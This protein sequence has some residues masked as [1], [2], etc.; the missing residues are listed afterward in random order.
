MFNNTFQNHRIQRLLKQKLAGSEYSYRMRSI[1]NCCVM[2]DKTNG[3]HVLSNGT[4][5]KI[6]GVKHCNHSW[7]CPC[8]TPLQMKK[9]ANRISA[10]IDALAQTQN[11]AAVMFTFTVFHTKEQSLQQTLDILTQS[12]TALVK[13]LYWRR[14]NSKGD[15]YKTCGV[16]QQFYQTFNITHT[17]KG[18]ELTYGEHGWHPHYHILLFVPKNK[19]NDVLSWEQNILEY[20]RAIEDRTAKKILSPKQYEIRDFLSW[21]SDNK[22]ISNVDGM[23]SGFY[24]SKNSDNTIRQFSSGNYICGWGGDNELT[25]SHMKTANEGHYSLLQLLEIGVDFSPNDNNEMKQFRK[26]CYDKYIEAMLEIKRRRLH[27]IDFSR[28]GINQIVTMWKNT[29]GYKDLIAKKK[30][31]IATNM[32]T[33]RFHNI[34]WFSKQQWLKICWINDFGNVPI[35]PLI[36]RFAC[37]DNG[38]ELICQLMEV[39]N[40]S[41]P[42]EK[43]PCINWEDIFNERFNNQI[44][45]CA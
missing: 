35:I 8:C 22:R 2:S 36:V 41:P 17:I 14:K 11:L 34:C 42:L 25:A 24:I 39:N 31:D 19:L 13:N 12:Y 5:T 9:F 20:W 44:S 3:V 28:T 32:K 40:L 10:A 37:Y 4:D 15:Y 23:K 27:R 43:H 26:N 29:Q 33:K 30:L 6:L 18:V 38:F 21:K 1:E 45:N 16:Y 7:G